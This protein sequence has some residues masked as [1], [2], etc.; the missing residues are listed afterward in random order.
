M[1]QFFHGRWISIFGLLGPLF[2]LLPGVM[3]LFRKIQG[4]P[5]WNGNMKGEAKRHGGVEA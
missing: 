3:Y 5:I 1:S 2:F 4:K